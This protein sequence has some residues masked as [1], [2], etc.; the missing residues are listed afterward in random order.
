[1]FQWVYHAREQKNSR[2][3]KEANAPPSDLRIPFWT[4]SLSSRLCI[5]NC[6]WD[7]FSLTICRHLKINTSKIEFLISLSSPVPEL[8]FLYISYLSDWH[9]HLPLTQSRRK[10]VIS[11]SFLNSSPLHSESLTS[12]LL[13]ILILDQF[14]PASPHPV[15][16]RPSLFS[17]EI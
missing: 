6:L 11:D 4:S 9:H 14:S 3:W 2:S 7:I 1:M 13:S 12:Y 10:E 17:P 16:N 5:S 8:L 15:Q